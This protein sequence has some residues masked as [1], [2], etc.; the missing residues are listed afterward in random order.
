[1]IYKRFDDR[2]Y[3]IGEEIYGSGVSYSVKLNEKEWTKRNWSVDDDWLDRPIR[4]WVH[5]HCFGAFFG[6]AGDIHFYD[7]DQFWQFWLTWAGDDE[8]KS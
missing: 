4:Q 2:T 3:R 5:E 1:M 8:H 7:E 6:A